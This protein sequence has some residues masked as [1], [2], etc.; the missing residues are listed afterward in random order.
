MD[1]KTLAK[2]I[3]YFL[4]TAIEKE[5]QKYLMPSMTLYIGNLKVEILIIRFLVSP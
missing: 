5:R 2:K 3:Q 1:S 4:I